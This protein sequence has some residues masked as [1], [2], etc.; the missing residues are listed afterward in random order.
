MILIQYLVY[1]WSGIDPDETAQ[2]PSNLV[3][4]RSHTNDNINRANFETQVDLSGILLRRMTSI[5]SPMIELDR[6][7]NRVGIGNRDLSPGLP[8]PG[9]LSGT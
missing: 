2:K 6:K 3:V 7:V 4:P 9:R 8:G 5:S 1:S